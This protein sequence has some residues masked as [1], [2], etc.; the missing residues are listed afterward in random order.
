[1]LDQVNI[2]GLENFTM[3]D[4]VWSNKDGGYWWY[5]F[6]MPAHNIT[7]EVLYKEYQ[8]SVAEMADP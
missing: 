1:M 5:T 4:L 7:T 6:V 3:G 2:K 8:N